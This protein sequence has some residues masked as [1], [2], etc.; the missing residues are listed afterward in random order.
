[1]E[2][3]KTA[4]TKYET[5]AMRNLKQTEEVVKEIRRWKQTQAHKY[6]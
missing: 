2:K 1:V 4:I 3:S 5:Y 6:L